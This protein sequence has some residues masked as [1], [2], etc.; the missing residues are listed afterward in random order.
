MII[1]QYKINVKI[2]TTYECERRK[3]MKKGIMAGISVIGGAVAGAVAVGK[4]LNKQIAKKNNLVDKHMTL[5]LMM[6]QWVKVKQEGK[7]LSSYL[8]K[9][10][11]HEIA[12][13]GM[14][15]AGET[16]VDELAG[17]NV[18]IKYA[19]DQN[20][21][22]IYADFNVITLDDNELEKV[23]AVVVTSITYFDEIEEKLEKRIDCPIISLEEILYQI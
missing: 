14:H 6:N 21:D 5:F 11:Y 8:E 13:Y 23:D 20:A 19:I 1:D 17:S 9:K 7:N 3:T 10:G 4:K 12:I 16:L 22:K 18:K 2:L 15:Y